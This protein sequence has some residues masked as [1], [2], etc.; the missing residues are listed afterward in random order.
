MYKRQ[1]L[2]VI[3]AIFAFIGLVRNPYLV[4]FTFGLGMFLIGSILTMS[5]FPFAMY[6]RTQIAEEYQGRVGSTMSSLVS[7]LSP[8]SFATFGLLFNTLAS[9]WIFSFC[10]VILLIDSLFLLKNK[11]TS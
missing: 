3:F 11:H 2:A 1:V 7:L 5:N 6:L 8:I 10:G 4:V 9:L